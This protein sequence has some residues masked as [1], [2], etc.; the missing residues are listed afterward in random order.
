MQQASLAA[1]DHAL[2]SMIMS[3]FFLFFIL[4]HSRLVENSHTSPI[5]LHIT[6]EFKSICQILN[7]CM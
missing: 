2:L 3:L 6:F 1:R 5:R 4:L 7:K